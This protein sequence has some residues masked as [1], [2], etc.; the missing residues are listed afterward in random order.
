LAA[1]VTTC[2]A[3]A[4]FGEEVSPRFC[5]AEQV[6]VVSFEN[7]REIRRNVVGLGEP[8]LPRRIAHLAAM[9]VRTLLCGAFNR[10]YLPNA[11]RLG[12]RVVTGISGKAEDAVASFRRGQI[13]SPRARHRRS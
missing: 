10:A 11:E 12:I 7:G 1:A 4:L 9:G 13:V 3:I 6:L 8:W 2:V 5:F